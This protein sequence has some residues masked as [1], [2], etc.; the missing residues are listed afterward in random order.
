MPNPKAHRRPRL[1]KKGTRRSESLTISK[2]LLRLVAGR[3]RCHRFLGGRGSMDGRLSRGRCCGG[4]YRLLH[5]CRAGSEEQGDRA[6]RNENDEFFHSE[7]FLLFP[8]GTGASTRCIS[9]QFSSILFLNRRAGNAFFSSGPAAVSIRECVLSTPS[10]AASVAG[11]FL[12][13]GLSQQQGVAAP[14]A[15]ASRSAAP[16]PA[17]GFAP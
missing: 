5:H 4:R 15:A 7:L 10:V 2:R 1:K 17:S 16:G 8:I 11:E 9:A 14:S 3:A 13:G 6:N 12:R